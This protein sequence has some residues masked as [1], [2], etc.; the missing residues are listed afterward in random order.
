MPKLPPN[1]CL[2]SLCSLLFPLRSAHPPRRGIIGHLCPRCLITPSECKD[3]EKEGCRIDLRRLRRK[4]W[5]EKSAL[6]TYAA[7]CLIG[8]AHYCSTRRTSQE[9]YKIRWPWP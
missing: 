2:L 9:S 6:K 1:T 7:S 8:S 4:Y 3:S 5:T